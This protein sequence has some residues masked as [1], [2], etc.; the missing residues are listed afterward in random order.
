MSAVP[1][2]DQSCNVT[3]Q[4]NRIIISRSFLKKLIFSILIREQN[5]SN[6]SSVVI[7][8]VGFVSSCKLIYLFFYLEAYRRFDFLMSLIFE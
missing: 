6:Q 7:D 8:L 4:K 1:K 3:I 5:I 2:F